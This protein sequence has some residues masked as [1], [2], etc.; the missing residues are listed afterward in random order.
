MGFEFG[1]KSRERLEGVNEELVRVLEL[2]L[3]KY[4][5]I[6]FGIPQYGGLRTVAEQQELYHSGKSK[7][8]GILQKSNHQSGN[9]VDVFAYV[10]GKASWDEYH[11][12]HI[13][14]AILR[15]ACE[16]GV[17]VKWGGHW[18]SFIDMPHY[19]VA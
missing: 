11:L 4:T 15:A 13:A 2:A 10:D 18:K 14:T 7:A 12:T 5:K 19:E 8:D 17:D 3:S 16:L 9:A 6:D 1:S